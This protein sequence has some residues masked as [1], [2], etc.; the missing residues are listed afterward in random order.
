MS[1]LDR[2]TGLRGHLGDIVELSEHAASEGPGS[3][4]N[5]T[6]STR[7]YPGGPRGETS[8]SGGE[9]TAPSRGIR[10]PGHMGESDGLRA[11]EHDW[12]RRSDADGDLMDGR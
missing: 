4:G 7:R 9:T 2:D 10:P 11:I 6:D 12:E 5:A 1:A 3:D 8:G